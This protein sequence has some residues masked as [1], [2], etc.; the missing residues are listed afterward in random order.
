[1]SVVATLLNRSIVVYDDRTRHSQMPGILMLFLPG[2]TAPPKVIGK[3]EAC[4]L[5][6]KNDGTLWVHLTLGHYTMLRCNV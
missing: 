3:T 4:E 5:A 2:C 1:M 6:G